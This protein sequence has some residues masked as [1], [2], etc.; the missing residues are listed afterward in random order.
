MLPPVEGRRPQPTDGRAPHPAGELEAMVAGLDDRTPRAVG[1]S[2]MPR[3]AGRARSSPRAAHHPASA[4]TE[5]S[6][7]AGGSALKNR[8][9]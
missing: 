1:C 8:R 3:Y 5:S 4:S 7:S 2:G 6:R 9:P